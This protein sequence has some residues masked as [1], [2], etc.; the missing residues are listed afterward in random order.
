MALSFKSNTF[1]ET[2]NTLEE[3]SKQGKLTPEIARE[4]VSSKGIDLQEFKQANKEFKAFK[5]Q[6]HIKRLIEKGIDPTEP[7][8]IDQ[9]FL[10]PTRAIGQFAEGVF[11]LGDAAARATLEQE[12]Y[13]TIKNT[14]NKAT[15]EEAKKMANAFT[16]PYHGEGLMGGASELTGEIGSYL[17][18][19]GGAVK[20]GNLALKSNKMS[21]AVARLTNK[22]GRKSKLATK[23][24]AYGLAGAIGTTIVE[25]PNQNSVDYLY[26][27]LSQDPEALKKLEEYTKNPEDPELSDY[28][29][30]LLKNIALEVPLTVG[31]LGAGPL[32]K[33]VASKHS[34]A[35]NSKLKSVS[36]ALNKVTEPIGKTKIG[37]KAKQ[38]LTSRRGTDDATLAKVIEREASVSS[39][40]KI[41]QGYA[42]DLKKSIETNLKNQINANPKYVEEVVDQALKGNEEAIARLRLDSKETADIVSEM[43]KAI[44]GLQ[45][46][47]SSA[48]GTSSK[49]SATIDNS[50]GTYMTRSYNVFDN[51]VYKKD[52]QERVKKRMGGLDKDGKIG[53][54]VVDNAARY[55][56]NKANVAMD[57]SYVQETLEKLVGT[58]AAD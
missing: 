47:F 32:I 14:L 29:N 33:S 48:T 19:A 57:D 17:I 53:D 18:G 11:N 43:N 12:T 24:G 7:T 37:R 51:P 52:I 25:D 58:G 22:M 27:A 45:K 39:A 54:E 4:I 46:E 44:Q 41:A 10:A 3:I 1:R 55:I 9:I 21:P 20:L 56:A 34:S 13:D 36:T 8:I 26:A 49:L 40:M 5:E 31:F 16:D 50:L 2:R 30:A 38:Y 28:F 15:P 35:I 42:D 23:G 6:P